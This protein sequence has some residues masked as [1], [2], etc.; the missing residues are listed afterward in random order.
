M[1]ERVPPQAVDA[2]QAVLGAVLI[3]SNQFELLELIAG[4]V[5]IEDFYRETHQRIF[6]SM[7]ELARAKVPIDALTLCDMLKSKGELEQIG[8][9]AYIGELADCVPSSATARHYA[10]MVWSKARY[11]EY[12]ATTTPLLSEAWEGRLGI[13]NFIGEAE[14]KSA[15]IFSKIDRLRKIETQADSVLD[16]TSELL[17]GIP[18]GNLIKT[19]FDLLDNKVWLMPGDLVTLAAETSLGKTT[20]AGNMALAVAKA[21]QGAIFFTFEMSQKQL[22]QRLICTLGE[23]SADRGNWGHYDEID[24]GR[25]LQAGEYLRSLP[26]CVVWARGLRPRDIRLEA[27]RQRLLLAGP[28]RLV[29]V[30]YLQLMKSDRQNRNRDQDYDDIVAGLKD[31]AGEL[32]CAVILLSQFNREASRRSTDKIQLAPRTSDL[33]GSSAI[34]QYSDGIWFLWQPE[35][36][37]PTKVE[38]LVAKNRNGGRCR[39]PLLHVPEYLRFEARKSHGY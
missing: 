29:V 16:S 37:F 31:L 36:E 7:L 33:K 23:V 8:G 12:I 20:I 22:N 35:K 28:L 39:I 1:P 10:E 14:S 15:G 34:E 25:I 6:A 30:D 38:L 4:L 5:V 9:P 2:E 13:E 27:R 3:A 11:R 18:Q 17:V 19:G 26:L 24:R 32:D 21:M